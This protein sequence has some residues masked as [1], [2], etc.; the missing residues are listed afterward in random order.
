[1]SNLLFCS[2]FIHYINIYN[3]TVYTFYLTNDR[4]ISLKKNML[5]GQGTHIRCKIEGQD[6]YFQV[7]IFQLTYIWNLVPENS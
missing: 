2:S 7:M 6:F 1:M 3:I 4:H 5:T